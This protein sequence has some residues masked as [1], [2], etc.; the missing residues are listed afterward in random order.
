MTM[1]LMETTTKTEVSGGFAGSSRLSARRRDRVV[2]WQI[3]ILVDEGCPLC[4]RE[5]ALWC[6]LD[7]GRNR[8]AMENIAAPGFDPSLYGLTYRDVMGEIHGI[9]PSGEIVRGVEVFRRTYRALGLGWLT[10]PTAWPILRHLFDRAYDWFA[11]NRLRIAGKGPRCMEACAPR[12][13]DGQ[14][15]HEARRPV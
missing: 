8:V 1:M 5:A 9:L 11:R 14:V 7:R 3:K 10:A 12:G 15:R 13:A 2:T 6:R 4:R